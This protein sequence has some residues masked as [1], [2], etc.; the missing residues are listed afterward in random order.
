[1]FKSTYAVGKD[2]WKS[3]GSLWFFSIPSVQQ[4]QGGVYVMTSQHVIEVG[5]PYMAL[6]FQNWL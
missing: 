1:M 5:G 4:G 3:G 6:P 2:P